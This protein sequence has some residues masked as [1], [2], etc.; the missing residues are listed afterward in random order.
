MFK[1][2]LK[3]A[4]CELI[5]SGLVLWLDGKDFT[6][7]P[8]STVWRDRSGSG[9][10]VIPNGMAYTT[11]SGSTGDGRVAFDGIDDYGV[12]PYNSNL[13]LLGNDFT[14]TSVVKFNSTSINHMLSSRRISISSNYEYVFY[15]DGVNSRLTFSYTLNGTTTLAVYASFVPNIN[16]IYN[17]TIKRLGGNLYFYVNGIFLS[18][19]TI[20]GT[21]YQATTVTL[22]G[23]SVSAGSYGNFLNGTLKIS[24]Q[25]NRALT[26]TEMLQNGNAIKL[27]W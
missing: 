10:N 2:Y 17:I 15:Y 9:N 26:D 21:I 8:I 24:L 12:I 27:G 22:I 7:N 1:D 14:I 3:V 23:A 19:G 5:K 13:S 18:S 6:N 25:Y 20:A 16:T 4:P 11:S